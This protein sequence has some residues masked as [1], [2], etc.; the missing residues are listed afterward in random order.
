MHASSTSSLRS[1]LPRIP[2]AAALALTALA[3][4]VSGCGFSETEDLDG[5]FRKQLQQARELWQEQNIS[6]YELTYERLEG[7]TQY[8]VTTTVV[9]GSVTDAVR[10]NGDSFPTEDALSVKR[11]FDLIESVIE[12]DDRQFSADFNDEQGYPNSFSV[13]RDGASNDGAIRTISLSPAGGGE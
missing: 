10:G 6:S 13:D 1:V 7:T 11:F 12:S 2:A 8:T 5:E 9:D 3:L 4:L